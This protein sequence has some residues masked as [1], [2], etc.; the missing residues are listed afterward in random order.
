M[1]NGVPRSGKSSIANALVSMNPAGWVNLGVDQAMA[2]TPA[3]QQPGI[4]LRPGDD[5]PALRSVLPLL[6]MKVWCPLETIVE[7]RRKAEGSVDAPL[8]SSAAQPIQAWHDAVY[9]LSVEYALEVDT[10][11]AGPDHLAADALRAR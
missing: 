3:H 10:S 2:D 8:A 7:R 11:V 5:R 6:W 1:L 9:G 4:G